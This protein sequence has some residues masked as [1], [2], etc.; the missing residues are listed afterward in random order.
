MESSKEKVLEVIESG[1]AAGF[2]A[3][4][5]EADSIAPSRRSWKVALVPVA[6]AVALAGLL[7][8]VTLRNS[9]W[10]PRSRHAPG[11][12]NLL[13]QS[14]HDRDSVSEQVQ[15]PPGDLSGSQLPRGN[16]FIVLQPETLTFAVGAWWT[17]PAL[18]ARMGLTKEQKTSLESAFE[19]RKDALTNMTELIDREE[20]RFY[21]L[22]EA[23]TVDANAVLSQV[24]RVIQARADI[25]HQTAAMMLEMRRS[26][27]K[28]Q[29]LQVPR[30]SLGTQYRLFP[31]SADS[32]GRRGR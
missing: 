31:R 30:R 25:E 7:T 27:S 8:I 21:Q 19:N 9:N 15:T 10:A 22:L 4:S 11:D 6:V 5:P 17:N 12:P 20:E 2:D 32:A 14:G 1:S 13:L 29:W 28:D 16:P 26:V 18:A 3:G 23:D 24:D